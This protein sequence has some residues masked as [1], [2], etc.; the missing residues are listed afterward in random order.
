M[1]FGQAYNTRKGS[2]SN[3]TWLSLFEIVTCSGVYLF[4]IT[5]PFLSYF[6]STTMTDAYC[7][8][9]PKLNWSQE[10]SM[11]KPFQYSQT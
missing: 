11:L 8:P 2:Y 10:K 1:E 4:L 9:P 6:V 7:S 3:N 5:Y